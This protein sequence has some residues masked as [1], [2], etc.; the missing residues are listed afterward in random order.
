MKPLRLAGLAVVALAATGCSRSSSAPA[1]ATA[2]SPATTR[3]ITAPTPAAAATT[4]RTT[5]QPAARILARP[6]SPTPARPTLPTADRLNT[7]A[8]AKLLATYFFTA[9]DYAERTGD[10][11]PLDEVAHPGCTWCTD[12]VSHLYDADPHGGA[13]DP[14]HGARVTDAFRYDASNVV[15]H[16]WHEY[17]HNARLR[18]HGRVT[19]ATPV[20]ERSTVCLWWVDGRWRVGSVSSG[21]ATPTQ[22]RS[23]AARQEAT[24]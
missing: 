11:G 19:V 6:L 20:T 8:A 13:L 18:A 15:V 12:Q 21:W 4:T 9:L 24:S 10:H 16:V 1:A 7:T 2:P 17:G 14:I 5:Q 3:A 22:V 23:D